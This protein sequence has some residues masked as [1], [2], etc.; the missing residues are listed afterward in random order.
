MTTIQI[1]KLMGGSNLNHNKMKTIKEWFEQLPQPQRFEAINNVIN[2]RGAKKLLSTTDSLTDA[3]TIGFYWR[4][5]PEGDLYWRKLYL[6]IEK[7]K[8]V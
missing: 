2:D 8:L 4:E 7:Q 5:S 3:L 1:L 6:E